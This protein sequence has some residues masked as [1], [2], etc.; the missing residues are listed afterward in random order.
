MDAAHFPINPVTAGSLYPDERTSWGARADSRS[1]TVEEVARAAAHLSQTPFDVLRPQLRQVLEEE[2]GILV[3]L[4]PASPH[5]LEPLSPEEAAQVRMSDVTVRNIELILADRYE[6]LV[7]FF[8]AAAGAG[9]CTV[10]W[11]A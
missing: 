5:Y 2:E 11:A 8:D 7:V 9:Q 4:D 3:N 10:F 6:A 1:L